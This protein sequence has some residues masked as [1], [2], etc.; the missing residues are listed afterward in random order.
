MIDVN[1][2]V[3]EAIMTALSA[4]DVYHEVNPNESETQYI[5]L[6]TQTE[7]DASNKARFTTVGT[8]LLDIVHISS[9]VT[10]DTVDTT[11]SA[12]MNILQPTPQTTGLTSPAGLQILNVKKLS[13][14]SL[15]L[16]A[17]GRNVMRRILRY[18]YTV[19]EI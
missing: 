11:A 5:L 7:E 8:I 16:K 3:R 14:N 17:A 9:G 2:K 6:N 13:S 15:T 1:K 12:V 4:Y 19:V 10:Y 18:Q